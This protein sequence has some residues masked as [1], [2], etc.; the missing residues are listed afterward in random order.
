VFAIERYQTRDGRIPFQEWLN[1]ISDT[2]SVYRIRARLARVT[3]GN[4]GDARSVGSGV[5][6]LRIDFGPGY[7]I[8]FA[9]VGHSTIVLLNGG[10]KATQRGD[11]ARAKEYCENLRKRTGQPDDKL[12]G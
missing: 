2:V 10:T 8:Y 5:R 7:R 3:A 1:S 11:M 9:Q 6:E 4:L 12:P